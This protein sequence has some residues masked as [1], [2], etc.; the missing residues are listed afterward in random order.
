VSESGQQLALTGMVLAD[1]AA[2]AE[3]KERWD[4]AIALLAISGQEFTADDVRDIAG[5]PGDHV[6]AAGPR[7]RSAALA[8]LIRS[9]GFRKSTRPAL[10]AHHIMVWVGTRRAVEIPA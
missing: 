2:S 7:F 4:K 10:R 6:N 3:W 1:A 9:V 8:G 5:P